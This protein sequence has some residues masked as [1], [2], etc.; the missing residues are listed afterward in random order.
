MND[1]GNGPNPL[2]GAS[3]AAGIFQHVRQLFG[4]VR[5]PFYRKPS[6]TRERVGSHLSLD[7]ARPVAS[8]DAHTVTTAD[9][10][11]I[12]ACGNKMYPP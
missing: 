12:A 8:A 1:L 7:C 10:Q 2:A 5:T 3:V 9:L 4:L 11:L 6:G